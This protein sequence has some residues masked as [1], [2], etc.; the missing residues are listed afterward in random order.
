[1]KKK[2]YCLKKTK[3]LDK[4]KQI[5]GYLDQTSCEKNAPPKILAKRNHK[6]EIDIHSKRIH[7][8]AM[9]FQAINGKSY[10]AFPE[11]SRSHNMMLFV[12]E[13]RKRNLS[14][15]EIIPFIDCVINDYSVKRENMVGKFNIQSMGE[16]SFSEKIG[17]YGKTK[18]YKKT[19]TKA[20][21]NLVYK[22]NKKDEFAIDALIRFELLDNLESMN[23]G[24]FLENEKEIVIILDN[25]KPHHNNQFKKFCEILKIKLIYLP[26]YTPWYNPIEQVWKSIKRIIYDPTITEPE[27]LISIFEEEYYRI[28]Y[29]KSFYEKWEEKFL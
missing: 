23:I 7:Q 16:N 28:I 10:I 18:G 4:N 2:D 24:G 20:V 12:A 14:N 27:I 11:N 3:K 1:M 29:N 26:A 19:F 9:G 21:N 22:E 17:I 13:I 6:N 25:Y 5:I 8:T 15:E